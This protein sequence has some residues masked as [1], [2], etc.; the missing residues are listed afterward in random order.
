MGVLSGSWGLPLT[1]GLAGSTP[2]TSTI[3]DNIG[4]RLYSCI[5]KIQGYTYYTC[6]RQ[7]QDHES[8]SIKNSV[9]YGVFVWLN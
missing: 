4:L 5:K 9:H 3:L 2:V 7:E 6:Q 1:S 8:E